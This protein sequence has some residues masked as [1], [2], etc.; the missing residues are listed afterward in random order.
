MPQSLSAILIHLVFST[1]NRQPFITET[2]EPELYKYLGGI[3]RNCQCPS[4]LIGR[5]KDHIHKVARGGAR[6]AE[7]LVG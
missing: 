2:I 4:L 6:S 1:K 3:F 7:P 5:E